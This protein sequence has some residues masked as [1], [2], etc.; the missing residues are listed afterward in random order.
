MTDA[1]IMSKGTHF[2][3]QRLYSTSNYGCLDWNTRSALHLHQDLTYDSC[4][5]V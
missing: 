2:M 5:R 4:C 1:F 3:R